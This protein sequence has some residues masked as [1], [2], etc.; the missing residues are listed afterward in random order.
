M[1]LAHPPAKERRECVKLLKQEVKGL[2]KART[3]TDV[4]VCLVTLHHSLFKASGLYGIDLAPLTFGPPLR[5][6]IKHALRHQ[7]SGDKR[8]VSAPMPGRAPYDSV[9]DAIMEYAKMHKTFT[10][11]MLLAEFAHLHVT[12]RSLSA[13][14]YRLAFRGKC[15]L[16]RSEPGEIGC[17]GFPPIYSLRPAKRR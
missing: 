1:Q 12:R 4:A 15:P 8:I 17:K 7:A 3:L 13:N 10:V 2:Q 14:L 6:A 5:S 16:K 9:K 11:D